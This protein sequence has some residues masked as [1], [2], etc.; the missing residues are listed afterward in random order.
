MNKIQHGIVK[1]EVEKAVRRIHKENALLHY[2]LRAIADG[3][4]KLVDGIQRLKERMGK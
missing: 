1:I 2:E 3:M 4:C